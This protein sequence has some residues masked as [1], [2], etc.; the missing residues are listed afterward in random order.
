MFSPMERTIVQR[1]AAYFYPRMKNISAWFN[2]FTSRWFVQNPNR[3]A[4]MRVMK[5]PKPVQ[6]KVIEPITNIESYELFKPSTVIK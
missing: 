3:F 1:A 6:P 4:V 2:N 5:I